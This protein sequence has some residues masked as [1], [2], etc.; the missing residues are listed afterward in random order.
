MTK[1]LLSFLIVA[2]VASCSLYAQ[3]IKGPTGAIV[4]SVVFD[5]TGEPLIGAIVFVVGTS[6]GTATDLSGIYCIKDVPEGSYTM[7]AS[8]VGYSPRVLENVRVHAS[9][10]VRIDFRLQD[11]CEQWADDARNDIARG[12]VHYLLGG[13]VVSTVPKEITEPIERKYGVSYELMGCTFI[14]QG[15]YNRIVDEHLDK[16]NR[17]GWREAYRAELDSAIVAYEREKAIG[18][19]LGE[20]TYEGGHVDCYR[21]MAVSCN[22]TSGVRDTLFIDEDGL[23]SCVGPLVTRS[24]GREFRRDTTHEYHGGYRS[25]I[26]PSKKPV[27]LTD[28]FPE[29]EILEALYRDTLVTNR[30]KPGMRPLSVPGLIACLRGGCTTDFSDLDVS[31]AF[32]DVVDDSVVVRFGLQQGCGS[33]RWE[34]VRLR[35]RLCVPEGYKESF[36]EAKQEGLLYRL[37]HMREDRFLFPFSN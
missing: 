3:D 13:L 9:D 28:I 34:D 23:C 12:I 16:R 35:I 10:T 36:E 11:Y 7:K 5:E 27:A 21:G 31:Y 6:F 24:Y 15:P 8:Y 4:G 1:N 30:L 17:R 14:C 32:S 18:K 20:T 29:D 22:D 37:I 2:A 19:H 33:R 26:V 25:I